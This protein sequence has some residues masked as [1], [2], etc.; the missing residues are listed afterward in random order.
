MVENNAL[1][2]KEEKEIVYEVGGNEIK[3]TQSIV[4]QFITK[5]NGDITVPEAVNFMMWCSHNKLDPFNNEAYLVKFGNQAAQQLVGKGAFMRRAE[6]DKHYEGFKAGVILLRE[7]Q[8][9]EQ[10]GAFKLP[11]DTL[12]GGWCE[13]Y[14]NDKKHPIKAMVTLEE[15]NKG[16]STWKSM[17]LTMIRKVAIVQALRE[18]FPTQLSGLYVEDEMEPTKEESIKT[19]IEEVRQEIKEKV[20]ETLDIPF[21]DVEFEENEKIDF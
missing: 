15:Y 13:V 11:K 4:K 8:L 16:Q 3:L 18:A 7:G 12:V 21:T 14:I 10:E 5:G 17:P 6:E 19:T 20:S 1:A 2:K 9:V